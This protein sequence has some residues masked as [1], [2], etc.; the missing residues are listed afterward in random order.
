MLFNRNK[1]IATTMLSIL[2]VEILAMP[3]IVYF[4]LPTLKFNSACLAEID[5]HAIVLFG[6][7]LWLIFYLTYDL[8][9][10][11]HPQTVRRSSSDDCIGLYF[12]QILF[13]HPCWLG[14]GSH[15]VT[16]DQ[17]WCLGSCNSI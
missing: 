1:V 15:R 9:V 14:K 5:M 7:V 12:I 17:G 6:F 2:L 11:F 13:R 8:K 3:I 10:L 4:T 16:Y